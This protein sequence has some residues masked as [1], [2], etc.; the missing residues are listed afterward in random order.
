MIDYAIEKL[1]A[2]ALEKELIQPC[3]KLWALNTL[4]EVLELDSY[5]PSGK[6]VGRAGRAD[7]RCL[8]A[9]RD[10]GEL[11]RLPRPV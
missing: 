6:E 10:E 7:G 8:P 2:Y 11:H 5:T 4:L 9:W 1:L 3:E